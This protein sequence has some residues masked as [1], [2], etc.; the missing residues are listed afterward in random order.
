MEKVIKPS[1]IDALHAAGYTR[2][3]T[4]DAAKAN[5]DFFMIFERSL[6]DGSR[7]IRILCPTFLRGQ[8]GFSQV[9]GGIGY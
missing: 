8:L 6:G 2:V 9:R 1:E 5:S 7:S 3:C 4:G